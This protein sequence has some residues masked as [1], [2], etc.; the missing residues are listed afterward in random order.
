MRYPDSPA[1]DGYYGSLFERLTVTLRD[2]PDGFDSLGYPNVGQ[3][4]QSRMRNPF[5]ID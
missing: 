4:Y 3:E 2:R 5:P 1:A